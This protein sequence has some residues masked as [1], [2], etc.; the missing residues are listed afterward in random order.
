MD[1]GTVEQ[2]QK[3]VEIAEKEGEIEKLS[4]TMAD[5]KAAAEEKS[6]QLRE[7]MAEAAEK[8]F[9]ASQEATREAQLT[10]IGRKDLAE[11]AKIEF[12]FNEKILDVK[13][14]IQK[15]D[16]AGLTDVANTNRALVTQLSLEKQAALAAH[17]KARAEKMAADAAAEG[18]NVEK[19]RGNLAVMQQENM[20]LDLRLQGRD[21]EAAQLQIQFDFQAKINNALVEANDLW[22]QMNQAYAEGNTQ[23]GDQL[24]IHAQLK[25]AEA[26]ELAIEEQK[27]IELEQQK[28][29]LEEQRAAAERQRQAMGPNPLTINALAEHN[30]RLGATTDVYVQALAA[31]RGIQ[32]GSP[33]Y[34]RLFQQIN[35]E[36]QLRNLQGRNL[37]FF[38]QLARDRLVQ[39]YADVQQQQ[40]SQQAN[41]AH[42]QEIDYWQAIASGRTPPP[43]NPYLGMFG[44]P[45]FATGQ[46]MA[47]PGAMS[48]PAAEPVVP[49][50]RTLQDQNDKQTQLLETI[51]DNTSVVKI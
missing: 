5:Q 26:D 14:E 51:A 21:A 43:G 42:Q 3:L 10:L 41:I 1:G 24:A 7:R 36:D 29:A 15:A 48:A 6:A 44:V 45:N 37:S 31:S 40:A 35:A 19:E 30:L 23:L 39:H 16:E 22:A 4:G 49:V 9:R 25:Q 50:L 11:R 13:K 34:N 27:T 28:Q 46:M 2:K 38:D 8:E 33:E 18:A 17:D 20:L 32:P 12:E 47:P